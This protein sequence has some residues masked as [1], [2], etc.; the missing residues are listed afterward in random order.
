MSNI[1]ILD[2]TMC[3]NL[4]VTLWSG[5]RRLKP[6]DLG[7]AAANLPPED[8]ASLGSL[9]LCDPAKLNK[10]FTIKRGAERDCERVCVRFLGGY[11]TE[12]SN[13]AALTAKLDRRKAEFE[14]TAS[15]FAQSLQFEIDDWSAKHPQWRHVI[16]RAIPDPSYITGRLNFAYQVFRVGAASDEAGDALNQGLVE[17]TTGLAGQLFREIQSEARTAWDRSYKG[18]DAVGQRALRPIRAIQQKLEALQF[19][20]QRIGPVIG[21]IEAVLEA[22]PKEGKLE[23][24]ELS[25]VVGLLHLL[26][27]AQQMREHGALVIGER[28]A[29]A[30]TGE[31][32][33]E[34][35]AE[36]ADDGEAQDISC[37]AGENAARREAAVWI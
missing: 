37:A 9:K 20:D 10:L 24:R 15:A 2:K 26:S 18:K 33:L 35:P 1:A 19:I 22:L 27:D 14:Q 3:V 21:R 17:Q 30:R 31:A 29:A 16:E 28:T 13:V 36:P 32:K 5:R 4:L 12:E 8:L 7:A 23:G 25:A 34:Q 6:E 11:A